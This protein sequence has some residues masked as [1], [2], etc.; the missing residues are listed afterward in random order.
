MAAEA[1]KAGSGDGSFYQAKLGTGRFYAEQLVP[2]AMA[3]AA[4]VQGGA[5]AVMALTEEQL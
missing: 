3:R 4:A 1:L 2:W 5:D